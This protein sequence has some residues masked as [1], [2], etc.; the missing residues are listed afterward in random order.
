M[1]KIFVVFSY[2]LVRS[3]KLFDWNALHLPQFTKLNRWVFAWHL[4]D[5]GV[6][7]F[8]AENN[9]AYLPEQQTDSS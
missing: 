7:E 9:L 8:V 2:G 1:Q 4:M 3:N 6:C 5:V